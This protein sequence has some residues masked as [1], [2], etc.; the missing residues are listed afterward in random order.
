MSQSSG[1]FW[2]Y[3]I[4]GSIVAVFGACVATV[5]VASTLPVEKSDTYMMDYHQADAKANDL[6]EAQIAFDKKYSIK[7]L[8]EGLSMQDTSIVY[9][10]EDLEGNAVNNA[11]LS[12]VVTRPNSHKYDMELNTPTVEN[13]IYTFSKITLP[14][15]GR[16]DI[17]AKVQVENESRFYNIKTDT[18]YKQIEEY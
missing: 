7:L 9:E 15:E 5:M 16:W 12:I 13:G 14:V 10:I 17:M 2:P 8:N 11:T 1:R 3:I 18:R 4:G 6:I